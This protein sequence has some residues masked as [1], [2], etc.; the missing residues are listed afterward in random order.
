MLVPGE[1][2]A[3]MG[4]S[5]QGAGTHE[6][7]RTRHCRD[8]YDTEEIETRSVFARMSVFRRLS[9]MFVGDGSPRYSTM[10]LDK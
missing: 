6:T 8:E 10:D 7:K 1:T 3:D 5:V 2:E 9:V 4:D